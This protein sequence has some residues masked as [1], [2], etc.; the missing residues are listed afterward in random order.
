MKKFL[1]IT[2]PYDR[3]EDAET[4]AEI[5]KA[6]NLKELLVKAK[7]ISKEDLEEIEIEERGDLIASMESCNGD[8]DDLIQVFEM[9][10][11][12]KLKLVFG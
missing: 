11:K 12:D 2:K 3:Y 10:P 4:I 8:G 5:I 7:N 9:L 6:K 1:V